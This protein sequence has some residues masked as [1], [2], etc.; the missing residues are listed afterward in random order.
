MILNF[1]I[2][3]YFQ[4]GKSCDGDIHYGIT[5]NNC[6]TSPISGMR[7]KCSECPNLNLC[8]VC[9]SKGIHENHIMQNLQS[10][11][12]S[13]LITHPGKNIT[14]ISYTR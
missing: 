10:R 1:F 14:R 12:V 4:A 9:M 2:G 8:G 5:C 13:P 6:K 3:T 11:R 7:Y